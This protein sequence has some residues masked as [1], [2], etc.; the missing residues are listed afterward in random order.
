[1]PESVTLASLGTTSFVRCDRPARC[2]SP[3]S[4]TV[5][6]TIQRIHVGETRGILGS[7]RLQNRAKEECS[8]ARNDACNNSGDA[9]LHFVSPDRV[10]ATAENFVFK[11]PI[12][13]QRRS[14]GSNAVPEK[15][16]GNPDSHRMRRSADGTECP[17]KSKSIFLGLSMF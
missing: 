16:A 8:R 14:V 15:I 5:P 10:G 11:M 9:Y 3:A 1:M 12:R 7:G 4:D 17:G 13:G 2:I 6:R